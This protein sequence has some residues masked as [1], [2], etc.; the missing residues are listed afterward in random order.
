MPQIIGWFTGVP[1]QRVPEYVCAE[2]FKELEKTV[3]KNE[4]EQI[5][6]STKQEIMLDHLKEQGKKIDRILVKVD[7]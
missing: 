1:V 5:K 7:R 2:E 4:R 6:I 3:R